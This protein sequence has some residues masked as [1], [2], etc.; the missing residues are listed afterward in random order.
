L[1]SLHTCSKEEFLLKSNDVV[2]KICCKTFVLLND[3]QSRKRNCLIINIILS[4]K[5][6]GRKREREEIVDVKMH[7]LI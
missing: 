6:V 3:A 2:V 5:Q 1:F 7:V 4:N